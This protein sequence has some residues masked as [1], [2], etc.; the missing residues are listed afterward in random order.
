MC[1]NRKP[2]IRVRIMASLVFVV[3]AGCSGDSPTDPDLEAAL[4]DA[5]ELQPANTVFTR[6]SDL[7]FVCIGSGNVRPDDH[8][9][10][11]QDLGYYETSP[12]GESYQSADAIGAFTYDITVLG[13]TAFEVY[14]INA[15]ELGWPH[16][17]AGC[18][19]GAGLQVGLMD[20]G[21]G[22]RLITDGRR[23]GE[24]DYWRE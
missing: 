24:R 20:T 21:S 11:L 2:S 14:E 6:S 16:S 10:A 22:L 19:F 23:V 13:E 8:I 18:Y 4:S 1:T 12:S 17:S 5:E 15:R 7:K 3:L 9:R